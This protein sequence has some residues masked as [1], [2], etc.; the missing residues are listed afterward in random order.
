MTEFATPE[1][2][3]DFDGTAVELAKKHQPRNWR[4][5]PLQMID[6]Y[7]EFLEGVSD[8]GIKLSGIVSRRPNI[9]QRRRV[10]MR[11]IEENGLDRFFPEENVVLTGS[12]Q[13]KAEFILKQAECGVVVLADDKPHKIG[14]EILKILQSGVRGAEGGSGRTLILGVAGEEF[15]HRNSTRLMAYAAEYREPNTRFVPPVESLYLWER[16]DFEDAYLWAEP[17]EPGTKAE[18]HVEEIA[19][20]RA[21]DLRPDYVI[22]VSHEDKPDDTILVTETGPYSRSA[23]EEFAEKIHLYTPS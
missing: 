7:D 19:L 16:N 22:R 17:A 4:K 1:L 9:K 10:T 23:G 6:G 15:A 14:S 8:G 11:S 20:H 12:E 3:S 18:V 21:L 2:W 5:Y 13:S